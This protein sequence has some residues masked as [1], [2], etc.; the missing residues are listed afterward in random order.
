[1]LTQPIRK[2]P[3]EKRILEQLHASLTYAYLY[4]KN[5][6][7][8][9]LAMK[10]STLESDQKERERTSNGVEGDFCSK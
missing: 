8:G 5:D 10:L 1:M 3:R 7:K 2:S 4:C 6:I 9:S